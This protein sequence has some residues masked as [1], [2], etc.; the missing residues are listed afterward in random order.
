MLTRHT[1]W[2]YGEWQQFAGNASKRKSAA[3]QLNARE[4][5][6][7][8]PRRSSEYEAGETELGHS[9]YIIPLLSYTKISV[10]P[11]DWPRLLQVSLN[12]LCFNQ[13]MPKLRTPRFDTQNPSTL[14]QSTST[15]LM[16]V[17]MFPYGRCGRDSVSV[18]LLLSWQQT[19]T[20]EAHTILTIQS[21]VSSP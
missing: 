12:S 14:S 11:I 9:T 18:H 1:Q 5:G 13:R 21:L 15:S 3:R 10:S 6:D 19:S 2:F 8:R 16:I 20:S 7:K 4:L 17:D